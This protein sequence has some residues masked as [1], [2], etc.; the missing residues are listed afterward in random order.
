MILLKPA[1]CSCFLLWFCLVP[2]PRSADAADGEPLHWQ[3]KSVSGASEKKPAVFYVNREDPGKI[4]IFLGKQFYLL[5]AEYSSVLRVTN[6][7]PGTE[8]AFETGEITTEAL[9]GVTA[10]AQHVMGTPGFNG[11]MLWLGWMVCFWGNG[12]G[13][14]ERPSG[15][16]LFAQFGRYPP[17]KVQNGDA[18]H[19]PLPPGNRELNPVVVSEKEQ[20][21]RLIR[22]ID[23]KY[24]EEAKAMCLS[25]KMVLTLTIDENGNVTAIE[26]AGGQPLLEEA[27]IKA[28]GRW[29]YT[30]KL[31]NGET[32]P[33]ITTVT[34]N[35]SCKAESG[36]T[37]VTAGE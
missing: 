4:L 3:R 9:E 11:G 30:P 32:L 10:T 14:P 12:A 5:D 6:A 37:E 23:P 8:E 2:S 1:G 15:C 20:Q 35:F 13:D 36:E 21:M 26:A 31:V 29:K 16:Y 34:V 7:L 33:V 17:P 19:P 27:A 24:P 22:K 18:R 28:V 25:G